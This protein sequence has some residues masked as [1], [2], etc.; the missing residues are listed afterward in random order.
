[1]GAIPVIP[2]QLYRVRGAG[3]DI[4]IAACHPCDALCIAIDLLELA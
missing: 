3:I 2:G 4:C 1:M